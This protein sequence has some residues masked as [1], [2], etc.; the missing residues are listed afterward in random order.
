MAAQDRLDAERCN[1]IGN[2][3]AQLAALDDPAA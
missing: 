1:W 2:I 3:K